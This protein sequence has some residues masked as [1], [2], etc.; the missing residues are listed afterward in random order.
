MDV[1]AYEVEGN[2]GYVKIGYITRPVT[3]CPTARCGG[4][5][6]EKFRRVCIDLYCSVS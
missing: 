5:R 1:Y 6:Y 4:C 2:S 3:K